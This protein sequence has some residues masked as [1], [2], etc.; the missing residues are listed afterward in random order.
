MII[1]FIGTPGAGKTTLLPVVSRYLKE[2]GLQ[3]S[4]V[5]D[6]ARPFA[7]RTFPG[8]LARKIL[9]GRLLNPV[10]WQIFY[11]SSYFRR[12]KFFRE[13]PTLMKTVQQHQAERPLT[14][15][16]HD[17]VMRWFL[18]LTGYYQFF[19]EFM[20][21]DDVVVYDEGF[22]HRVV[23]LFASENE[24]PDF[25]S[26]AKYLDLVPKPDLVV[27]ANT[28]VEIC[29]DRVLSRGVWERFQKKPPEATSI[30]ISHASEVVNFSVSYL[31]DL[32][33]NLIEVQNGDTEISAVEQTLRSKLSGWL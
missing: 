11:V 13:N 23:Q 21:S 10:L 28:P 33:W 22:V 20:Q 31:R 7:Q 8:K 27:F 32:N 2:K 9:P 17:H 26:V 12:R 1:E 25:P 18:H 30:F 14:H 29:E 5:L 4:S 16:D 24:A 3:A 15:D 19:M 6:A